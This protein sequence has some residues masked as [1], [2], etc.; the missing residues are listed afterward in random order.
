ML[1]KF[2]NLTKFAK[3]AKLSDTRT[4]LPW[5]CIDLTDYFINSF[6]S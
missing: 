4:K 3:I 5:V 6:L 2:N 1:S